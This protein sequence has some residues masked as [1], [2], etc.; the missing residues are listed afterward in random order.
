MT[1][2]H[3]FTGYV[4]H[5]LSCLILEKT[6]YFTSLQITVRHL[7]TESVFL[8]KN[9]KAI[10][11]NNSSSAGDGSRVISRLDNSIYFLLDKPIALTFIPYIRSEK[12]LGIID[13]NVLINCNS[14]GSNPL[15]ILKWY[16]NNNTTTPIVIGKVGESVDLKMNLKTNDTGNYTC[17]ASNVVGKIERTFELN[18]AGK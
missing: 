14:P 13:Q 12:I 3:R 7:I 2:K 18:V 5:L 6:V 15:S 4:G 17:E 1:K 8:A 16:K 9:L 10:L 11:K